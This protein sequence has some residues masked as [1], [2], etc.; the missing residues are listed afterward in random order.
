MKTAIAYLRTARIDEGNIDPRINQEKIIRDFCKKSQ[1]ELLQV[2]T[3][4]CSGMTNFNGKSWLDL[5]NYIL[6]NDVDYILVS[7]LDRLGRNYN[8]VREKIKS[9]EN[10]GKTLIHAILYNPASDLETYPSL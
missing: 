9:F 4:V 5:E 2:F 3:D 1:T 6:H 7:D 10:K 8:V